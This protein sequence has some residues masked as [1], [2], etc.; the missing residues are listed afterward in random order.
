MDFVHMYM[1]F[2]E[3]IKTEKNKEPSDLAWDPN[4]F[5]FWCYHLWAGKKSW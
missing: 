1:D 3:K 4:A 5:N 2:I